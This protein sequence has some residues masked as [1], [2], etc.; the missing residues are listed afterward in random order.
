MLCLFCFG[1]ARPGLAGLARPRAAATSGVYPSVSQGQAHEKKNRTQ[2]VQYARAVLL[3]SF[4]RDEEKTATHQKPHIAPHFFPKMSWLLVRVL[5]AVESFVAVIGQSSSDSCMPPSMD[6]LYQLARV[7]DTW[8]RTTMGP[9][10]TIALLFP[11]ALCHICASLPLTDA[12]KMDTCNEIMGYKYCLLVA[13]HSPIAASPIYFGAC[14]PESCTVDDLFEEPMLSFMGY[15]SPVIY[16]TG[17]RSSDY[18][19][20]CGSQA[21][22]WTPGGSPVPT[23]AEHL[24]SILQHGRIACLQARM[25]PWL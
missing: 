7:A 24:L 11:S 1:Q 9:C 5:L 16:F 6:D 10:L 12:G 22:P 19:A 17:N 15:V 25:R 8:G 20:Y 14:V 18:T 4:S 2:R 13:E 21:Q 3:C 23:A